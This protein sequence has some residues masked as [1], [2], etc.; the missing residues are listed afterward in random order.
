MFYFNA[1]LNLDMTI[2]SINVNKITAKEQF[3]K[4]LNEIFM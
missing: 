3:I 4:E 2:A 1:V